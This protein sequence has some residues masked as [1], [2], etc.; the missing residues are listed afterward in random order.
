ML[1]QGYIS[2]FGYMALPLDYSVVED[3][4]SR[5]NFN[6]IFTWQIILFISFATVPPAPIL[7]AKVTLLIT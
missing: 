6:L 7:P 4:C 3:S 2:E 1:S 5:K